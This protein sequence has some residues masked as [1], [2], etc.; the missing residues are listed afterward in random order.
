MA[1]PV[2]GGGGAGNAAGGGR[3]RPIRIAFGAPIGA[4]ACSPP[5]PFKQP[6]AMA[7]GGSGNSPPQP[8][9][10]SISSLN[11]S[12]VHEVSHVP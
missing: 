9:R 10:T 4:Q 7:H 6:S 5:K 11:T 3:G 1:P 2:E 8:S 12:I